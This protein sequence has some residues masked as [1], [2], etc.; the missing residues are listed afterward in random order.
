MLEVFI[1]MLGILAISMLAQER[2]NIPL[3]FSLLSLALAVTLTGVVDLHSNSAEVSALVLAVLPL[4]IAGDTISV[5]LRDFKKHWF[6]FFYLACISVA[7]SVVAAL[8]IHKFILP[9]Y[10]LSY[11][12]LALLYIPATATDPVAVSAA[13]G[14]NKDIPRDLKI[15]AES[16]SLLN[17]LFALI[18]FSICV[19]LL[20]FESQG[21][22]A[23]QITPLALDVLLMIGIPIVIGG[24]VG[25]V[26]IGLLSLTKNPVIETIIIL[27]AAYLSFYGAEHY[28]ASGI[29]AIVVSIVM[30][31]DFIDLM[32][33][34]D[35]GII[36]GA[37]K[38]HSFGLLKEAIVHKNNLESVINYI[39]AFGMLAVTAIFIAMVTM[40]N[41]TALFE[42][43]KAIVMIFLST[44]VIRFFMMA[45]FVGMTNMIARLESMKSSWIP[46]MGFAGVKGGLSI[47]MISVYLPDSFEHKALFETIISGV[48]LLSTLTYPLALQVT[49][50][51][52]KKKL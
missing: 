10:G 51:L 1:V 30:T 19:S 27:L 22:V 2:L 47:V 39:K 21:D 33:R 43:S 8:S 12:A 29:L 41:W 42:H 24:I 28:H 13:M 40:L 38:S 49:I 9:E 3:P 17:D 31:F 5:K 44:T 34:K 11:L 50:R 20:T 36:D 32:I 25:L 52:L 4:L 45:K 6:R 15:C 26:G 46:V 14:G 16:E 18:F 37:T 48:I 23:G 35:K 7:L